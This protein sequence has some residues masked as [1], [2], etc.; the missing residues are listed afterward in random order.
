[1]PENLQ[2]VP[3][4]AKLTQSQSVFL[5]FPTGFECAGKYSV[6]QEMIVGGFGSG[7][8]WTG[9]QKGL[10]LS[11]MYPGNEGM[12]CRL[13]GSD[14][15]STITEEFLKQCPPGWIRKIR[16]RGRSNQIVHLQNGSVIYFS[17]IRDAGQ[18]GTKTRRTGHNLGW[19]LV[20]QAE[21]ITGAE[22]QALNG[23]L[24][25]PRAKI[26]F[27]MG[28]ANPAG[29]N[30]LQE[31]FFPD[32]KPLDPDT[33]TFYRTY[34]KN[35]TIGVHVSSEENRESNGGF[36]DDGTFE[37]W[38]LNSPQEWIDRYINA[39][40]A[41]FSGR[42]YKEYSLTS[43]H[44]IEPIHDIPANW[45]CIG[46]ID[47]GG[48]CAW[49]V[50]KTF[51]DPAGNLIIAAE[52]DKATDLVSDVATWVKGQGMLSDN[53][54][55]FVIDPENK[56]ATRDLADFGIYANP[57]Q[58][59]VIANIQRVAGY[60]HPAK[61]WVGVGANRKLI[62]VPPRWLS[63]RQPELAA[64]ME[65]EGAPRIFVFNTC[66]TWRK[67]HNSVLWDAKRVNQIAKTNVQRFDSVDTTGYIVATRPEAR[68][69]ALVED[70]R[71]TTLRAVNPFAAAELKEELELIQSLK[72]E[73]RFESLRGAFDD[74]EVREPYAKAVTAWWD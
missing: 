27:A 33:G 17:H 45:E 66:T 32:W 26:R 73:K 22:W 21:E 52:F 50:T 20:E 58:K 28:N 7:K 30:W 42:V 71:I 49:N 15:T 46:G 70:P 2:L 34:V 43:V 16:N 64:R 60:L 4:K 10:L 72:D 35:N 31:Y 74:G 5:N 54:T 48:A 25:N 62:G 69:L 13:H 53:R 63:E 55:T 51:V 9:M 61:R 65:R 23:R 19:F 56:V 6:F 38:I 67:E 68:E 1:M 59:H 47:V 37:N 24:R 18:A 3:K 40:F 11:A 41:D 44:N 57:A 39:S 14:M 8:S 12:I 29:S 36:V